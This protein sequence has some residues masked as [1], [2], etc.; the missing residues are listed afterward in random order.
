MPQRQFRAIAPQIHRLFARGATTGLAD[1]VLLRRYC[2]GGDESAFETLVARHGPMVLGVCRSILRD[3]STA[4]DAFQA[5]FLILVRKAGAIRVDDSLGGWLHAVAYKVARRAKT[6]LAKRRIREGTR[7]VDLDAQSP[8]E[9]A[10]DPRLAALHEEIARLPESHRQALVYC[11]LEGKTQTEAA[12]E[13]GCGEATVRRRLVR[14]RQRLRTRLRG[15]GHD[16]TVAFSTACHFTPTAR[17]HRARRAASHVSSLAGEVLREMARIQGIKAVASLLVI[18]LMISGMVSAMVSQKD[19][20]PAAQAPTAPPVTTP[21]IVP[22]RRGRFS[23]LKAKRAS[24]AKTD[25]EDDGSR[26]GAKSRSPVRV[27]DP[28][29]D[30]VAN[31]KVFKPAWRIVAPSQKGTTDA[32]GRLT[33]TTERELGPWRAEGTPDK[34]SRTTI[35]PGGDPG[36]ITGPEPAHTDSE[37]VKH[38][39]PW[40]V[41][42]ALG[43]GFG[44]L[45]A[46]D[47]STLQLTSRPTFP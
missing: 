15:N 43:Y 27:V 26:I 14:A 33:F 9:D 44:T 7:L 2:A 36:L 41:A 30:P 35:L 39:K 40:L 28:E 8:G 10:A 22:A 46:G 42:T 5:V 1:G 32:E 17:S 18:G 47:E 45:A 6:N 12:E 25:P 24:A 21:P 19:S 20:A 38:I 16:A 37:E 11:W 34:V 13:I 29:G 4:E 3:D 23:Q 31:A